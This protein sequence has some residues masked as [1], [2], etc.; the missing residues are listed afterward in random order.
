MSKQL[1]KCSKLSSDQRPY[2]LHTFAV[3]AKIAV[4]RAR[5]RSKV[6]R[7]GRFIEKKLHVIDEAEQQAGE[8]VMKVRFVLIDEL[9][10]RQ[11][12]KHRFQRL[13]GFRASLLVRKRR[14]GVA[15]I[16]CLSRHAIRAGR[17][18]G[19]RSLTHWART[20]LAFNTARN[21]ISAT[22]TA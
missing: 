22:S 19:K 18:R 16:S 20:V 5:S 7:P 2:L 4:T 6:D 12:R 17:A 8:F 14:N 1:W 11:C 15:L 10:P 3:D 9:G 13:F 21:Q